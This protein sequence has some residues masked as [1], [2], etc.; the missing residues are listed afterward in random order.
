VPGRGLHLQRF[1]GPFIVIFFLKGIEHSLLLQKVCACG[2]CGFGFQGSV[3]ALMASVLLGAS[4][5]DTLD[6]NAQTQEPDGQLA[7]RLN[8][9]SL[10]KQRST[11]FRF[12]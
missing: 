4:G 11:A 2:A 3:H 10:A 1:V 5:L 9:L 7:T 12:L 8:I 6:A